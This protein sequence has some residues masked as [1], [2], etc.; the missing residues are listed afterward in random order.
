M[1]FK[2]RSRDDAE[3]APDPPATAGGVTLLRDKHGLHQLWY[4]EVRLTEELTRAARSERVFSLATWEP[5]LLPG[6]TLRPDIMAQVA[7]LIASKLRTYDVAALISESRIAAMLLDA[8]HQH[9][10]TVTYRIRADIQIEIPGAG[11]WRAG[12]ATF[13]RDGVDGDSL[14]QAALRRMDDSSSGAAA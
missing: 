14:I 7:S 5:R 10:S 13:G 2:R 12:V 11:K 4:M 9:A 8:D 1:L 6:D 3:S